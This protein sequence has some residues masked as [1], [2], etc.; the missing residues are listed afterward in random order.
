[1]CGP[2]PPP[3]QTREI[4]VIFRHT[5][6]F[7]QSFVVRRYTWFSWGVVPA[8]DARLADTLEGAG[9]HVPPGLRCRHRGFERDPIIVETWEQGEPM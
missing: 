5:R 8:K 6:E 3:K 2:P 9:M 4:Y 7:P 1:M